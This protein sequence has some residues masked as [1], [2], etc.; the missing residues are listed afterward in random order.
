MS[1]ASWSAFAALLLLAAAPSAAIG[2][3]AGSRAAALRER[4]AA[5]DVDASGPFGLPLHLASKQGDGTLAGDVHARVEHRFETV[6]EALRI[7]ARWCEI[8]ILH[9][10]VKGCRTSGPA[11]GGGNVEVRV[12]RA[13]HVVDFRFRIA[14]A[15]DDY[16]DVRLEAPTGPAGTSDYRIRVEA[17]PLDAQATLLHLA[18]SHGFGAQARLAM[19]AYFATFGRDKVGFTVVGRDAAGAPVHVR[20]LRGGLERNAMRYYLAIRAYLDVLALPR[21][22]RL[23]QSLRKWIAYTQRWP[24]QLGEDEGHADVKRRDIARMQGGDG[25][26]S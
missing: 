23:E 5:L 22:Q 26:G 6:R 13:G 16:L 7:S 4:F 1:R 12:G 10:N 25:A 20:D 11:H 14:A 15:T 19:D 2:A 24:R 21:A 17:T 9:P 8:M 3:E 18:Y